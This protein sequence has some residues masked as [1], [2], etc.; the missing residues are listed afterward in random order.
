VKTD[1]EPLSEI[2]REAAATCDPKSG[3]DAVTAL[4]VSFED[5]DR[6]A[7][8]VED[9]EGE[10]RSTLRGIDPEGDST[11]AEMTAALAL[12][13]ATSPE[14]ANQREDA[15]VHA[16]RTWFHGE[17]PEP[18]ADWLRERGADVPSR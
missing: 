2:V 6:P 5:D 4:V 18:V 17:P 8:G 14:A 16:A 12:F 9:L 11:P 7:V 1:T 15:L 10:L 3:D 13:I